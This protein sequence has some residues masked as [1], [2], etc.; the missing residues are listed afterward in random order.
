MPGGARGSNVKHEQTHLNLVHHL[1]Q[2]QVLKPTEADEVIYPEHDDPFVG[3]AAP[4]GVGN[5]FSDH[6]AAECGDMGG[7]TCHVCETSL[8]DGFG[9]WHGRTSTEVIL[10]WYDSHGY[11]IFGLENALSP[12]WLG[13]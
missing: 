8:I 3:I 5:H 7:G 9:F 10:S 2:G 12:D 11:V 1:M 4:E 13:G 6:S